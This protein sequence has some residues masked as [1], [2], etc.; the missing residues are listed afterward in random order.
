MVMSRSPENGLYS[1]FSDDEEE[2]EAQHAMEEWIDEVNLLLCGMPKHAAK[3]KQTTVSKCNRRSVLLS[4]LSSPVPNKAAKTATRRHSGTPPSKP[5]LLQHPGSI[6][7]DMATKWF[8][9]G[10]SPP[11]PK[12]DSP[13]STPSSPLSSKQQITPPSVPWR[14]YVVPLPERPEP[15]TIP[16]PERPPATDV[17]VEADDSCD[18]YSVASP[19]PAQLSPLPSYLFCTCTAYAPPMTQAPPT[20]TGPTPYMGAS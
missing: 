7:P 3:Q 16:L 19:G 14:P 9:P 11:P 15:P 17:P 5:K 13:T 10:R 6:S 20:I 12:A 4:S 1:A 18:A 8:K 2:M